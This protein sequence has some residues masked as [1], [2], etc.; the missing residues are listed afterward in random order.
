MAM[1]SWAAAGKQ[2]GGKGWLLWL[3]KL[4][5]AGGRKSANAGLSKR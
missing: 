5:L 2:D 1:M 4:L 3:S